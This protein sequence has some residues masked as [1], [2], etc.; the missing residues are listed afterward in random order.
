[1]F[2]NFILNWAKLN[3]I[4][5]KLIRLLNSNSVS[6]FYCDLCDKD[7]HLLIRILVFIELYRFSPFSYYVRMIC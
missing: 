3:Y 4:K 7:Y 6:L 1:M 5:G 2:N